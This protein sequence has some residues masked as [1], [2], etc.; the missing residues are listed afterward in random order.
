VS[1][2]L[3]AIALFSEA[4][5]LQINDGYD[6]FLALSRGDPMGVF[7]QG[8]ALAVFPPIVNKSS[9]SDL[10]YLLMISK[11]TF[12]QCVVLCSSSGVSISGFDVAAGGAIS[13]I[14]AA[15]DSATIDDGFTLPRSRY[16]LQ[17]VFFSSMFIAVCGF[18]FFPDYALTIVQIILLGAFKKSPPVYQY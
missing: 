8:G 13:I 4:K 16:I 1:L 10:G 17:D 6:F 15:P 11:S 18:P 7:L 5:C 14:D 3:S 12:T 2:F 9:A